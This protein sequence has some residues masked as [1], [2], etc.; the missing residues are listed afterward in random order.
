MTDKEVVI[1]I[2]GGQQ[3]D[4]VKEEMELITDGVF[5]YENGRAR[6]AYMESELTG[7]EGT[8]TTFDIDP[9]SIIMTREGTLNSQMVFEE[10]KRHNFLYETPFGAATM[11]VKTRRVHVALDEH[12]GD[13]EVDYMVE[14]QHSVVGY[15][16][17][18]INV[19]E[20]R[21]DIR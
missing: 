1:S 18:T 20:Q 2:K 10:G 11:G 12:G 6:L 19:R 3:G 7:L 4:D 15:N 5:S 17:V 8:R 16:Y 14:L 13:M 9:M 21:N